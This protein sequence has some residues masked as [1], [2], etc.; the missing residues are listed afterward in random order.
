MKKKKRLIK[1]QLSLEQKKYTRKEI[2]KKAGK[3]GLY[4]AASML[5]ILNPLE[6][7]AQSP[8]NS[9]QNIPKWDS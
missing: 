8:S 7:Q 9:P 2:L 1:N 6:S 3:Y 5:T 4:T